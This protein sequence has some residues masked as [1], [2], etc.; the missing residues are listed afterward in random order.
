MD[1]ELKLYLDGME[2]RLSEKI[3][4]LHAQLLVRLESFSA[5]EDL[6]LRKLEEYQATSDYLTQKRRCP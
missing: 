4:H 1:Q 5:A 6:R 2:K 3:G